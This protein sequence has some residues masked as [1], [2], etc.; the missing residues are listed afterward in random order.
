LAGRL[1]YMDQTVSWLTGRPGAM[2]SLGKVLTCEGSQ[3][4]IPEQPVTYW[5]LGL[6]QDVG[7]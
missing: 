3:V 5:D 2:H 1:L 6:K 7:H 4:W